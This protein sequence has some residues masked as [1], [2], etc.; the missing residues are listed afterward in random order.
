MTAITKIRPSGQ[1]V[2]KP[3]QSLNKAEKV[4]V[5]VVF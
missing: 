5:D 4:V 1:N 2:I 3:V